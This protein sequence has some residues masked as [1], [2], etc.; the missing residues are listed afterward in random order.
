MTA[1]KA[2]SILRSAIVNARIY[3]KGSQMIQASLQGAHQALDACLQETPQIIVSDIQGKLCVN[4][5]EAAEAKDFRGF[6]VQ[7]DVQSLIFTKG[8][9]L[10]EVTTL[11]EG[12]GKRKG[13]LDEHKHLADW[14]KAN[15]ITHIT[16]EELKFVAVQ[17]GEVV[18]SQV[19][20]LLEQSTGDTASMVGSSGR[21]L[22]ADGPAS[23]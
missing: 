8:L 19:L 16:A 15:K 22:P 4:G 14:L 9:T 5:K 6:L 13:Q 20:Q 7:H 18:V 21:S 1:G 17:T 11:I 10:E 3:P 12:L 23:G 2:L